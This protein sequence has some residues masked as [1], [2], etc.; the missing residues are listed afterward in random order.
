M[1]R[2]TDKRKRRYALSIGIGIALA[3]SPAVVAGAATA[4]SPT[5]SHGPYSGKSYKSFSTIVSTS[6]ELQSSSSVT[7]SP[8]ASMIAG[9]VKVRARTYIHNGVVCVQSP[10]LPNPSGASS[11]G[12][13]VSGNCGIDTYYSLGRIDF[14]YGS[15]NQKTSA[16]SHIDWPD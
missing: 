16:T 6:T 2:T 9:E 15:A 8:L 12:L 10:L 14:F 13:A 4:V 5:K 11:Y 1:T 3:I 7:R